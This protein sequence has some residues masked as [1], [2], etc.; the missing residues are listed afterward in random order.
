MRDLISSMMNLSVAMTL[1]GVQQLRNTV[2]GVIDATRWTFFTGFTCPD[3]GTQQEVARDFR[4]TVD[5][6][7]ESLSS[8]LDAKSKPTYEN[9]SKTGS[10]LV[11]R[12]FDAMESVYPVGDDL[13][14]NGD[15]PLPPRGY[16]KRSSVPALDPRRLFEIGE[17]QIETTV[18]QLSRIVTGENGSAKP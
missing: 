14:P 2:E 6:L 15:R 11:V 1:F 8:T 10:E 7:T 16:D 3:C 5:K 18:G 4:K 12:A 17:K 9:L 13:P